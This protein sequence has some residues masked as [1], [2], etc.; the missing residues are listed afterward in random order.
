MNHRY[1]I[2]IVALLVV[3]PG[4]LK[5][6][7]EFRRID[8][9]NP[10]EKNVKEEDRAGNTLHILYGGLGNHSGFIKELTTSLKSVL[11][12]APLDVGMDVHFMLDSSAQNAIHSVLKNL[13]SQNEKSEDDEYAMKQVQDISQWKMRQPVHIHTYNVDAHQTRWEKMILHTF[14]NYPSTLNRFRHSLGAY[15]RLFAHEIL[16]SN[17]KHVLYMD[18]DVVI[19]A[20]LDEMMQHMQEQDS[21]QYFFQW[22]KEHCSGFL[23]INVRQLPALWIMV[24]KTLRT[25]PTGLKG[26][27]K[28]GDQYILRLVDR[29]SSRVGHLPKEWDVSAGNG[30]WARNSVDGRFMES[31][32]RPEGVGMM[33]YNGGG[34]NLEAA[35]QNHKF[36]AKN[37]GDLYSSWGLSAYYANLP[38]NWVKFLVQSRVQSQ[39]G[40]Y[41][42]TVS[43]DPD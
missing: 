32:H 1:A 10:L 25:P 40:G 19:M 28:L 9:N 7:L 39:S 6:E 42:V 30:V 8:P 27:L 12:N 14:R 5:N 13:T 20:G 18:S 24:Q 17:V 11:L 36:V 37:R 38:W 26:T 3:I 23:T 16:P 31:H 34:G 43:Q 21:K 33:H 41:S 4:V 35:F 2:G 15:F 29:F 22:G